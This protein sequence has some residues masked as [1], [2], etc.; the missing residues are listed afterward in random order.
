[1]ITAL[2]TA[3]ASVPTVDVS[4]ASQQVLRLTAADGPWQWRR[5]RYDLLEGAVDER[6]TTFSSSAI[7]RHKRLGTLWRVAPDMDPAGYNQL[8]NRLQ[9]FFGGESSPPIELALT[10]FDEG[11]VGAQVWDAAIAMAIF[12]QSDEW[13]ELPP[14]VRVLELGAGIGLP[15]FELARR[16]SAVTL[17]DARPKLL[18]LCSV[19]AKRNREAHEAAEVPFGQVDVAA[20]T[21]GSRV[22]M[23]NTTGLLRHKSSDQP[24]GE[25]VPPSELVGRDLVIGSDVCYDE[26]GVS[27]LA[28]MIV[29]L[30]ASVTV[31]IGPIT[32]P[33]MRL[34]AADLIDRDGLAVE[35]RK[36]TLVCQDATNG[37]GDDEGDE[38]T[39]A[40]GEGSAE[41]EGEEGVRLRSGGVHQVLI[42][43]RA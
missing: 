33:S 32:R 20:L 29:A 4:V 27:S 7:R 14:K 35:T 22:E 6:T 9:F 23:D 2:M 17:T 8:G 18:D 1:M 34:L 39:G 31:I 13:P 21:W 37:D 38:R 16:V 19:N 15:S 26:S 41:D 12:Q 3:S 30:K 11:G 43:R 25:A 10:S 24:A 5:A 40:H 28:E 42:I 36:L